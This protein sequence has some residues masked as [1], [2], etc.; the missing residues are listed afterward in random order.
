MLSPQ[1]EAGITSI[2]VLTRP[3][4][5]QVNWLLHKHKKGIGA[6]VPFCSTSRTSTHSSI[7]GEDGL[8]YFKQN[9]SHTK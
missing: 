9:N 1:L 6:S 5:G 4:H 3:S 8:V 2:T 7:T